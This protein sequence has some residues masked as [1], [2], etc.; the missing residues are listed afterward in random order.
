[1]VNHWGINMANRYGISISHRTW[2]TRGNSDHPR[3]VEAIEKAMEQIRV[4]GKALR[5]DGSGPSWIS[6][7][8]LIKT[9]ARDFLSRA[10]V[11]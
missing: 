4:A 5:P 11:T 2:D 1:V 6:L 8:S 7:S 3:I 9:G 10:R